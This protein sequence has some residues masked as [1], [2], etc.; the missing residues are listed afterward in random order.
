MVNAFDLS[1]QDKE[2]LKNLHLTDE[3]IKYILSLDSVNAHYEMHQLRA[4]I[5]LLILLSR[6]KD[7]LVDLYSRNELFR[8]R[9]IRISHYKYFKSFLFLSKKYSSRRK[10]TT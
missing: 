1:D 10:A 9:I 7:L 4:R 6:Y 3:D 8:V 5:E 2:V